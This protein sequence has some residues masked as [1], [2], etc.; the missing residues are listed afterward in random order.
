MKY[1]KILIALCAL[2]SLAVAEDIVSSQKTE[3]TN[4]FLK[5]RVE[6]E[7]GNVV[8]V[9]ADKALDAN[10]IATVTV[11]QPT[12]ANLNATVQQANPDL[13]KVTAKVPEGTVTVTNTKRQIDDG[14]DLLQINS[15]GSINV[16]QT[17]VGGTAVYRNFEV[18]VAA[19]TEVE[20]GSYTISTGKTGYLKVL[21]G[22][23]S[24]AAKFKILIGGTTY[25]TYFVTP[26]HATVVVPYEE[27]LTVSAGT[28]IAIRGTNRE[29]SAA[30]LYATISLVER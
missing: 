10:I 12:A 19:N 2:T 25:G 18:S 22:A 20:L 11:A 24:G 14:T 5:T 7:A 23:S 21:T 3:V 17:G 15:D 4:P 26:S 13:L 1:L 27:M 16:R 29:S 28:V 6:D 9:G 30:T 8:N